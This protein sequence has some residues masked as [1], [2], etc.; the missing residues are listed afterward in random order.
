MRVL[1]E[2]KY[3]NMNT[4]YIHG[5]FKWQITIKLLLHLPHFYFRVV[6]K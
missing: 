2:N 3:Y 6:H 4:V 5:G 1:G